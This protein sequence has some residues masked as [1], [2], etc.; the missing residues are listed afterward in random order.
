MNY[1]KSKNYEHLFTGEYLMGPNSVKLMEEL[2]AAMN[3]KAG[4]RVLDLGCGTGI[5]SLFAAKE[6][7]VQVYAFDLWITAGDN[8]KRIKKWGMEDKIIPVHGDANC[9]PFA[10]EYFDAVITADSYFYYGNKPEFFKEKIAPFIK[11]G[12]Q[13]GM[14]VPGFRREP[15]DK[16]HEL[17]DSVLA[18]EFDAWHS[19]EWWEKLFNDDGLNLLKAWES[20]GFDEIWSDWLKTDNPYAVSD[21]GVFTKEHFDEMNFVGVVG[22]VK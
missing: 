19:L 14:I 6:Y 11:K 20:S 9:L 3:L 15:N 5:T 4:M 21:K 18:D 2:T 10:E 8:F 13:F 1:T 22:N 16:I 7:G 12:G 17:F